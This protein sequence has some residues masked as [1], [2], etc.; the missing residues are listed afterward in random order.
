[1]AEITER[2]HDGSTSASASAV[3][4]APQSAAAASG[5]VDAAPGRAP[6]DPAKPPVK[7]QIVCF[8]FYKVMPEWRRLPIEEKAAHK[9]AFT[10]VLSALE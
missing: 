8:S 9:A 3:A 1:M 4:E 2:Q 5:R 10:A 6:H 7:R